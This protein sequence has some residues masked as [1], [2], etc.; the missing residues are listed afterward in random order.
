MNVEIDIYSLI[1]MQ[2]VVLVAAVLAVCVLATIGAVV[3]DFATGIKAAKKKGQRIDSKGFR[4]SISKLGVYVAVEMSL[5]L[6]DT[7]F[8]FFPWYSVPVVVMLVSV[9]CIL[10][11][12]RSIYENLKILRSDMDEIPDV[13]KGLAGMVKEHNLTKIID[14]LNKEKEEQK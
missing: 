13:L 1:N 10:I 8:L 14:I 5:F 12:G 7:I 6:V 11:E 4:R 3:S 2:K 9:A